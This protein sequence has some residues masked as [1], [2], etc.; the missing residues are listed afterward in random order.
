MSIDIPSLLKAAGGEIVGKVRLQK[1]VY[2]LDQMGMNSG[3]SYEYHHYGP[4]SAELADS[5]DEDVVFG[6]IK[7][8]SQR[9]ASDGVPYSVFRVAHSAS[10][11][12]NDEMLGD[13]SLAKARDALGSMERYSATVLELAATIHWLVNVE[14]ISNWRTELQRR[15][16]AKVDQGRD[17]QALELLRELGLAPD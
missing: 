16:G 1:I 7:E 12:A 2:L 13:I 15:K 9:R 6:Q 5:V 14:R 10:V 17:R 11:A 3:Y 4:Y 8:I